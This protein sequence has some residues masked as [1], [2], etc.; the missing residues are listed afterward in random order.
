M[1]EIVLRR[2]LISAL[3]L[4]AV[5][6]FCFMLLQLVPGDPA[7]VIAGPIAPPDVVASVRESLGLDRPLLYQFWAYATRLASGDLGQSLIS[8]RP[9]STELA[10]AVGPTAELMFASL[11]WSI[12]VGTAL[13]TLAAARQGSVI[14][15][16]IMALS[17]AGLSLPVFFI[18]LLLTQLIGV[19]WQL[20]PFVGR[21]GPLWT[22]EG[23]LHIALPALSLGLIFIGPVARISRSS[24]LE[25]MRLDHVRTARAKGLSQRRVLIKH[26]LRNALIPIVTLVGLQA[27]YLMGGAVVTESIFSWPGIGRLAVGSIVSSDF[28]L[29][30]GAIMVMALSFMVINLLVDILYALLDP[31]IQK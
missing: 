6:V 15:R 9:V 10:E 16:A 13:G 29:A 24:V 28:A 23:L 8:N 25:V 7:Q 26:V 19:N 31:R 18:C 11:V 27:G 3:V 4:V 22:A 14:D 20:L 1:I 12:P 5:T 2:I 17:V 30:Q 21:E